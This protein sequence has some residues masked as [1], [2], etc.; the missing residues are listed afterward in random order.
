MSKLYYIEVSV[1][2]HKLLLFET[3]LLSITYNL[4]YEIENAG[5]HC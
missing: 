2:W 1:P 4:K 3:R 5:T